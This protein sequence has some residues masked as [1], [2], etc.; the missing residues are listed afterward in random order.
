MT[1]IWNL[2]EKLPTVRIFVM[3][4]NNQHIYNF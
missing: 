4:I 2:S 3:K 1:W